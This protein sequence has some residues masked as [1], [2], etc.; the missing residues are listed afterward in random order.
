[1]GVR[2]YAWSALNEDIPDME[3][4]DGGMIAFAFGYYWRF[5]GAV[6]AAMVNGINSIW[7]SA[8]GVDWTLYADHDA[9]PPTSGA[10]ARFKRRHWFG[11]EVVDIDGVVYVYVLGGDASCSDHEEFSGSPSNGYQTDIW[12]WRGP[13]Y[14]WERVLE[15]DDAPFAG[16]M[17]TVFGQSPGVLW[18]FG[19]MDGLLG[20]ESMTIHN[21]LFKSTDWGFTWN[22]VQADRAA[23]A[24]YPSPRGQVN[25]LAYFLGRMWLVGGGTYDGPGHPDR[26]YFKEVWS[27]SPATPTVWT[28]HSVA[29]FETTEYNSVEVFDGRLWNLGGYHGEENDGD[30]GFNTNGAWS[31]VDGERWCR[32]ETP[33]WPPSHADGTCVHGTTLLRV[34]GNSDCTLVKTTSYALTASDLVEAT[35]DAARANWTAASKTLSGS[36][37]VQLTDTT[38]NGHHLDTPGA[39]PAWNETDEDYGG[40][41]S[42]ENAGAGRF[43]ATINA[44]DLSSFVLVMALRPVSTS[45]FFY[46]CYA[47]SS[48]NYLY[49]G[50]NQTAG[51]TA[52]SVAVS[53]GGNTMGSNAL[54]VG[55]SP[56]IPHIVT[57]IYDGTLLGTRV[58]IDGADQQLV[59]TGNAPGTGAFDA[60]LNILSANDGTGNKAGSFAAG[61]IY[62]PMSLAKVRAAERAMRDAY[63][64][65]L[66]AP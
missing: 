37:V 21:W 17:L 29:P 43:L 66:T 56:D 52:L 28:Q 7:R 65:P 27:F 4:V 44:V 35:P 59:F 22:T 14:D 25:R 23:G 2:E 40:A 36:D 54:D 46:Y 5:A 48:G 63:P 18:A 55:N 51:R 53:R 64:Y 9:S 42:V 10:G 3:V 30:D 11:C 39:A 61:T 26:E 15:S 1:L 32:E 24:T 49:I 62:P 34:S 47:I 31:S 41:P 58:R 60:V 33:L 45:G 16:C 20:E 12:R 19:G 38:D 8:N 6:G 57:L 13:G 50:G